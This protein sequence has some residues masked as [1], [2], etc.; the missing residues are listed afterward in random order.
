LVDV[1]G[2]WERFLFS[3]FCY[4]YFGRSFLDSFLLFSV[5]DQLALSLLVLVPGCEE[6]HVFLSS[7][8]RPYLLG[9]GVLPSGIIYSYCLRVWYRT[10]IKRQDGIR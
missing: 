2:D 10:V 9:G 1:V 3:V 5:C 6:C 4:L 7:A 8:S